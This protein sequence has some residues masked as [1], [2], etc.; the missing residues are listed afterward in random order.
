M[1]CLPNQTNQIPPQFIT[2]LR[3]SYGITQRL[4]RIDPHNPITFQ[5]Y[6]IPPNTPFSM[7]SYIQHRNPIIF[8][9]PDVFNPDRWLPPTSPASTTSTTSSSNLNQQSQ[10]NNN[11]NKNDNNDKTQTPPIVL[12]PSTNRP[13]TKYLVPFGRGPRACLGQNFAM[14]ELFLGL[15]LVFRRF[16]FELYETGE[17]EVKMVANYFA[18]FPESAKGVR[19]KVVG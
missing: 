3:L 1:F 14:A 13:L 16:E 8:P 11:N 6:T 15:G 7:T 2:G 12:A 5:N 4:M 19:V 17:K 18:P 10:N 9:D